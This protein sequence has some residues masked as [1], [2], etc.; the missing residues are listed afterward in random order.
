VDPYNQY[1]GEGTGFTFANYDAYEFKEKLF[2]AINV[3]L[4][5][6]KDWNKL[7]KQAMKKDYSLRQMA[8]Q[9][10]SLYQI[11]LGV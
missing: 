1:T 3:Y 8:I 9:Y 4:K 7:I 10:E 11:I 6:P 5:K 2:E